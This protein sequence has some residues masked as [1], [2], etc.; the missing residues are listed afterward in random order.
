MFS[1]PLH[2]VNR[3]SRIVFRKLHDVLVNVLPAEKHTPNIY[4]QNRF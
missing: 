4:D 3:N 2:D 1:T